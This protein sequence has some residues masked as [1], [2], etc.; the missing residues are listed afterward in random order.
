MVI[1]LA[2]FIGFL[3]PSMVLET[4]GTDFLVD[5]KPT[6]LLGASYYGGLGA[7]DEFVDKDLKELK[8]YGFNWIRV[9][10]TWS[11][12]GNNVSAVDSQG[13]AREPYMSNLKKLCE[14]ADKLGMIVDVTLSRGNGVVGS[15]SL[16]SQES[17]LNAVTVLAEELKPYR[18]VYIDIGNERNIQDRRHVTFEE[19]AILRDR[20]KEIDPLRLVTASQ[21]GDI[22]PEELKK[23]LEEVKVDLITPHR[24]R[25]T[26]SPQET[27]NKTKEYLKLMQDM[28]KVVPLHYQEPFRRG[29]GSWQPVADDFLT[30][31][32][33]AKVNGAAG[34]C[35]HN[36]DVRDSEGGRPRRSFDMHS[37]ESR[38]FDQLDEEEKKV[39][40]QASSI[41]FR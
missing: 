40:S 23:Y 32:K 1:T 25:H 13:N 24:P 7:S 34:W 10:A 8:E 22:S 29:Y 38:L 31:L 14:K 20:I 15:G 30:D 41:A 28:G 11:A 9:W 19:L 35:L 39:I 33:N 36:G 26:G 12:F 18:N 16:P 3:L 4:Q 5:K 21:G 37:E 27:I 17:H 2:S 6:F